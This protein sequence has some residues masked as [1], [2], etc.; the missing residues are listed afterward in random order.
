MCKCSARTAVQPTGRTADT[1]GVAS[2]GTP[3]RWP[4]TILSLVLLSA[5]VSACG[6]SASN[7]SLTLR[8]GTQGYLVT[9]PGGIIWY[10]LERQ[11]SDR[12]RGTLEMVDRTGDWSYPMSGEVN[13]SVISLTSGQ[14]S[15]GGRP[16][17]RHNSLQVTGGGLV[18]NPPGEYT[19]RNASSAEFVSAV[20]A[21][22]ARW[23]SEGLSGPP[24]TP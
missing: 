1:T 15:N 9:G 2:L 5:L 4:T 23:T 12:V 3:R 19:F 22:R 8:H 10:Q 21:A 17:G 18:E 16:I 11:G 6:S 13:G 20:A 24:P 14:S 7:P